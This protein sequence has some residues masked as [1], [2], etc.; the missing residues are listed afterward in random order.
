MFDELAHKPVRRQVVY[1]RMLEELQQAI[2]SGQL[3]PRSRILS[4]PELCERYGISRESERTAHAKLEKEGLI[5]TVSG[6]T[7]G[8]HH[9]LHLF[10][11]ERDRAQAG[12]AADG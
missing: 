10:G 4:E 2:R 3:P 8:H 1:S 7:D 5:V 11:P 6:L 9:G 12:V